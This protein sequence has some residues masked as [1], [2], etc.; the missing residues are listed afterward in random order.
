MRRI[1]GL[2]VVV[3]VLAW[4]QVAHAAS[5]TFQVQGEVAF[6]S[7]PTLLGTTFFIGDVYTLTYTFDPATPDSEGSATFG[8]YDPALSSAYV[9]VGGYS[10]SST[11]P[12]ASAIRVTNNPIF[13]GDNYRVEISGLI[14]PSIG[15]L[16][17]GGFQGPLFNLRDP[18]RT[19][20]GSDALPTT[21]DVSDF[22]VS[23]SSA[24]YLEFEDPAT[25]QGANRLCQLD[26][27]KAVFTLVAGAF[28]LGQQAHVTVSHSAKARVRSRR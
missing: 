24:L 3:G 17:V 4:G 8:V 25:G 28:G 9:T 6:I 11:A 19:A 22:E 5:I 15:G 18:T 20:F 14:G 16:S 1:V 10:A 13:G 7:S 12:S 2:A 26:Q 23:F 21:L 27:A